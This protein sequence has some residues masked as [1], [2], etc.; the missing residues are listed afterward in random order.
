MCV[1]LSQAPVCVCVCVCVRACACE[2]VSVVLVN[3]VTIHQGH[4]LECLNGVGW[5]LDPTSP[6]LPQGFLSKT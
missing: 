6:P 4:T 1:D 3:I 5:E 2:C